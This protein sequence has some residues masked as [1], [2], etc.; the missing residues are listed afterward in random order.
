[1]QVEKHRNLQAHWIPAEA[2]ES[3]TLDAVSNPAP[4][5][6]K[7]RDPKGFPLDVPQGNIDCR[8]RRTNNPIGGIKTT[9][10]HTLPEMLAPEGILTD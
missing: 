6:L 7:D 10:R 2:G 1:V 9:A 4:Q 3:E 5:Q 8:K